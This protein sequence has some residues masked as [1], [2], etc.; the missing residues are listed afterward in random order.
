MNAWTLLVMNSVHNYYYLLVYNTVESE[1]GQCMSR[2]I[3]PIT[4]NLEVQ[5]S[6]EYSRDVLGLCFILVSWL[7]HFFDLKMAVIC[8]SETPAE[9]YLSVRTSIVDRRVV[10]NT[11]TTRRASDIPS[12]SGAGKVAAQVGVQSLY[13]ILRIREMTKECPQREVRYGQRI[14]LQMTTEVA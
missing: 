1:V 13:Y 3:S 5:A 6:Q 7:V 10:Q 4:S 9:C 8:T 12:Y 2:N 11:T 14:S